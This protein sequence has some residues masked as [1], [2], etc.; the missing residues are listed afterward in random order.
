MSFSIIAAKME[1]RRNSLG[2]ETELDADRRL[3]IWEDGTTLKRTPTEADL[4]AGVTGQLTHIHSAPNHL[5][6]LRIPLKDIESATNYFD[7]ENVTREGGFGNRYK[8]QLL[9][10]GELI[11]II[12]LRLSYKEWDD[13]KE[14]QFWTE[15]SI[16]DFLHS[17]KIKT[18]EKHHSFHTDSIW[19]AKG[20]S[21]IID[22]DNKYL[23]PLA[24]FHYKEK[25]LDG[26]I[27]HDLWKQ[28]E[29]QS[30][31]ILAETAYD[32]L[33]EEQF[34]RPNIDEIVTR[35]EKS[36]ELQLECENVAG[37]DMKRKDKLEPYAYWP[38]DRK[39]LATKGNIGRLLPHAKSLGF[40]PRRGGFPSGAKNE[41]GLSPKTKFE[42]YI[43]PN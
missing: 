2:K 16:L 17:M 36:L 11:D 31:N 12:A 30:L 24:M 41:W 32:C 28:M 14:Q 6:H 33:N 43:L 26:I 42:S 27:D 9:W 8:G 15:I 34:Q 10:S 3:I 20:K 38:L 18:S 1:K 39:M 5:A 35:L 22:H 4:D 23:A 25:T 29:T 13:K 21:I 37:G 40:K 19:Y 7:E